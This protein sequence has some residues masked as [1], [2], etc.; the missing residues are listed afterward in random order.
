MAMRSF[1]KIVGVATLAGLL[2]AATVLPAVADH[3][4]HG[5]G[6]KRVRFV[7]LTT[8]LRGSNEV[9]G[10]GDTDG[11]GVVDVNVASRSGAVC[12]AIAVEGITLPAT[13]AHI[14]HAAAGVAGDVVV[15]LD[16]PTGFGSGATGVSAG[17]LTKLSTSLLRDI[18]EHP[19][20]YYVNVHNADF[21]NGA[22]RGQLAAA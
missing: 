10:P 18:E 22:I 12:F 8:Q 13:A 6:T 4:H 19:D 3:R 11:T 21:P 16:P 2:A 14:H 17:C 1:R 5:H 9:P 7:E 20:Q 15:T